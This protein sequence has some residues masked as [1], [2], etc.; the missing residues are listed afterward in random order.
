M[1]LAPRLVRWTILALAAVIHFGAIV[2]TSN[3]GD[4]GDMLLHA[5][6][7]GDAAEVDKLIADAR[8]ARRQEHAGRD[9]PSDRRPA[10]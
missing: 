10:R 5:A 3:A 9:G 7:T 4:L 6:S 8:T 1:P 2:M